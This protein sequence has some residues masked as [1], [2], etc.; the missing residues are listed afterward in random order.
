MKNNLSQQL[1]NKIEKIMEVNFGNDLKNGNKRQVY[2]A[3]MTAT[4]EVLAEKRYEYSKKVKEQDAKQVYYMS[5]EFLVGTSLKNNLWNL[6]VEDDIKAFLAE[7]G[8]DIEEFYE[9]EPDAGLGNG[10]LGRLASCY[11]DSMTTLSY[12]ITGFSIRY[13]F[14]I[15]KQVIIDGWQNEFPDSWIDKAGYW[16]NPRADEE[17]EVHFFGNI[18]EHWTDKGLTTEHTDY[19]SVMAKPYDLFISG[20][21]TDAVNTLR[22]WSAKSTSGFNM[23]LF[24]KGEYVKST[25][26]E[27][28]ASSISK[29]LYPADDKMEGKSLRL[30]QQY[31]FVSASLQQITKEHYKKYGTFDNFSEKA[32]IH[33]NDTHPSLCVPE[34]MRILMDDYGYVWDAA[35]DITANSLAYTNHTVMSEALE[36]W[37]IDLVKSH[38]PRIYSIIEEINRRFCQFIYTNHG[39]LAASIDKMAIISDGMVKMANL[40]IAG[41]YSVNGVS[42]LHS[43]ILKADTFHDFN[44]VYPDKFTN[45][46]NGITHRR[47]L[48]QANPLL[49]QLLTEKI[50]S[51][52]KKS[53]SDIE[54]FN[55]FYNDEE[56]LARLREIKKENKKR[57]AGYIAQKNG[58][59]INCDSMFDVQV[60]RLHEYKR[61]LLNVLQIIDLYRKIKFQGFRPLPQTY[62]FA[63]K[64]SAGYFMAKEIIRLICAV[65]DMIER[66][67]DVRDYIKVVF[68]ADYKVSLAEIIIPAAD[69]SEQISQAGKEAS[70]TGNMKLMINGAVTLGT[71][72][73][74]NVEI[75]EAVGPENIFIFG[76][77][78]QEV[79]DL[80]HRGYRP[81]DY[82]NANQS[83][84][85]V[86]E[87][88][89]SGGIG[90]KNFDSLYNYLMYSDPYMNLAD[91]SSYCDAHRRV[92]GT[93]RDESKFTRM[94]LKNIAN[95]GI[96][97]SDRSVTDYANHI[98]HVKPVK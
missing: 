66:D 47:W 11:M 28:I 46:T 70:G 83:I 15:F 14:G 17:I 27:A 89:K 54:K 5:M 86:L 32:V 20:Y 75:Y 23:E 48:C 58:I 4:N 84:R 18:K 44:I 57:L 91:F 3:V 67:P 97:A 42:K 38:L 30:K 40:C 43:E 49:S 10:G 80:Y 76:L 7:N 51:G 53:L 36:K 24:S 72:D 31:F 50:G 78:T 9:M 34:L 94:S 62:I 12:P 8:F 19:V 2:E 92:E 98:W 1:K 6:E 79:N 74:A 60:K 45:V 35:W 90:G 81:A 61:Q 52:F 93:Y 88:I 65:S 13:E 55:D 41:S 29:V 69:I 77:S 73:G 16:L 21:N 87:F 85:D 37:P 95:A 22:L 33:I 71:M 82:Y 63:A 64:A 26:N 68:I 25:E 96:F 59:E 39:E 56:V